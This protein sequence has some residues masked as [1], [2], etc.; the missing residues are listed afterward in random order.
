MEKNSIKNFII[1]GSGDIF[2]KTNHTDENSY[3]EVNLENPFYTNESNKIFAKIKIKN[4]A[5]CGSGTY[6]RNWSTKE[7]K[8]LHHIIDANTGKP[9]ENIVAVWVKLKKENLS[10]TYTDALATALFFLE[11]QTLQKD[12]DFEYLIIYSNKKI[13]FSENLDVWIDPKVI[14]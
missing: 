1:D 14:L 11:P 7:N 8:N 2:Y 10:T 13:L 4:E 6:K 9:T 3:L 5:L 12:F